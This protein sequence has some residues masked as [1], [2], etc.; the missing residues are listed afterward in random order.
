ML[1]II[2]LINIAIILTGVI[3]LSDFERN[4]AQDLIAQSQEYA[5]EILMVKKSLL[6]LSTTYTETVDDVTTVYPAVPAGENLGSIHTLPT[7]MMKPQNPLKKPYVYCPFG[8]RSDLP[9]TDNISGG[10]GGDYIAG[11]AVLVK[12]GKSMDYI[13]STGLNQLNGSTILAF[14]ISPNPPFTGSTR[15]QDVRYDADLQHFVVKGGRVE[16][17]TAL[18]VEATNL[19]KH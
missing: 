2:I 9:M 5:A 6:A 7:M 1:G 12:N 14:I 18:E 4:R 13:T 17:I 10:A 15:C 11:K 16:T 3:A 8:A 19:N